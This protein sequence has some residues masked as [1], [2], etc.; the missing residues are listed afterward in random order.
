MLRPRRTLAPALNLTFPISAKIS[1]AFTVIFAI[2]LVLGVLGL[3]RL[4]AINARTLAARDDWLPSART[5]GELRT[6]VRQYRL[7]EALLLLARDDRGA[8]AALGGLHA[9]ADRVGQARAACQPFIGDGSET[10]R[11]MRDFDRTW[12][13]YQ[14][15][16]ARLIGSFGVRGDAASREAYFAAGE[17]P[18]EA[19]AAAATRSIAFNTRAGIAAAG[20]AVRFVRQTRLMVLAAL[21]VAL[22]VSALLGHALT[23]SVSIPVKVMTAAMKRL[24]A[25]DF[26]VDIPGVGRG[27]ELGAMAEAI[28]VFR[29][30]LIETERLRAEQDVQHLALQESETRFRAVFASV[31]DGI[32]VSDLHTRRLLEVNQAACELFGFAREEMLGR[33]FETLSAGIAP[34]TPAQAANW[35]ARA[36]SAGPQIFEWQCRAKNGRVFWAEISMRCSS[37]GGREVV[38]ATLRDIGD[39]KE[40]EAQIRHMARYDGLTGLP[41]RGAF[42]EAAAQ[43]AARARRDGG[44]FAVLFLD[45][46]HFKDVNDTLGHPVGDQL[47]REVAARLRAAVRGS[48]IVA[49][50]GGDEFAVLAPD[51]GGALDAAALGDKLIG[52]LEAPFRLQG[53]DVRIGTSIGIALYAREAADI[54]LLMSH[55]DVALYRA[56]A[57]GRGT[58]RFFTEAMD[59]QTRARVTLIA[60]LRE[61]IGAGQLFLVYQPQVELASGRIIGLEALVRWRHPRRGVLVPGEFIHEAESSGLIVALGQRVLR[62]TC[63]QGKAWYDAGILPASIAVNLSA[64]ELRTPLALE[65]FV[66]A[67]LDETGM[68]AQR[69]EIELTET[70]LMSA[71]EHHETL[72]RLRERGVRLAIDEFGT[73]YSSLDYLRRFPADRIKIAQSFIRQ[74]AQPGNAAVVK[75]TIGLARELG[76]ALI[77]EG[78]ETRRD[79][80]LLQAWGC[81]AA[82]GFYFAQPLLSADLEP[83]LRAG[84]ISEAYRGGA[85]KVAA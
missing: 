28:D 61:A 76:M 50:F 77:A 15:S 29:R 45:L 2:M 4:S 43:A 75:A 66:A 60:E 41:N 11:L 5:L 38:L 70:V 59:A 44:Q 83:L 58:Y 30:N 56:K 31:N 54:E 6:S 9:A 20:D 24:A 74:L 78:I 19:T 64:A 48:D 12:A 7:A 22:A 42:V 84:V 16:S 8:A 21:L 26:G 35:T 10:E 1:A 52:A 23:R 53:N 17:L 49:R 62:E 34:Y 72:A 55:A 85:R 3:D 32:F 65:Q 18:Y 71:G 36:Q 81:A 63:R 51:T 69:L 73:G 14:R 79:A 37:F 39:R 33:D 47:L 68:P 82:Q 40:A 46:D 27:D 57:E 25:R 67:T 13:D 80:E